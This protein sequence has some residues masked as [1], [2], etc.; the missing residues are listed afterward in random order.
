LYLAR[1]VA[2]ESRP[3]VASCCS[4]PVSDLCH[5]RWQRYEYVYSIARRVCGPERA[6]KF[7]IE[8]E[9]NTA[10]CLAPTSTGKYFKA[11]GSQHR[12][13]PVQLPLL[14]IIPME[15]TCENEGPQAP[16]RSSASD[17]FAGMDTRMSTT[18]VVRGLAS[19]AQPSFAG[20]SG[21]PS[22]RSTSPAAGCDR[23]S[24]S[25]SR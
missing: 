3:Y 23:T 12:G 9:R 21:E 24:R 5:D 11:A 22:A 6:G 4:G 2:R 17:R 10:R 16:K 19:S 14:L 15:R 25:G 8:A 7:D 18:D 20:A 13:H 1:P